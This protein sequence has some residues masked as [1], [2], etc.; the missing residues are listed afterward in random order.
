MS[1]FNGLWLPMADAS[2]ANPSEYDMHKTV[3]SQLVQAARVAKTFV[4]R[5]M[6]NNTPLHMGGGVVNRTV[7]FTQVG[8]IGTETHLKGDRFTG[9][10]QDR[11]QRQ[12]TLDNRP[13]RTGI[14]EE[15]I[16]KMFEQVNTRQSVLSSLGEALSEW[17]EVEAMKALADAA[18]TPAVG[19]E[20]TDEFLR[21]GNVIIGDM[22]IGATTGEAK[23]LATLDA[24]EEIA[25]AWNDMQVPMEGRNVLLP[26]EDLVE[27]I[28]L[29]KAH[30]SMTDIPGGIYGNLDIAG[31]KIS[32]T[33]FLEDGKPLKFRGFYLWSHSLFNANYNRY[34]AG[35]KSVHT[36]DP[37]HSNRGNLFAAGDGD[38][39]DLQAIVFHS[40]A[41]GKADVMSVMLEQDKVPMSTEEYINAMT[42]VGY[43]A[44]H[45]H[46]VVTLTGTYS[47]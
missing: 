27:I 8:R 45:P 34:Q 3:N 25:I 10:N 2:N 30:T 23:A 18:W 4:P 12:V 46:R 11:I 22:N 31:D 37:N 6:A 16:T 21:G 40:S 1:G 39:S 32:F 7:D 19:S 20:N 14:Q 13:R 9:L 35:V 33:E 15:H 43:G 42:W 5:M 38:M 29:E 47:S 24:L 28:R 41:V 17:D 44:L 36:L 26:I